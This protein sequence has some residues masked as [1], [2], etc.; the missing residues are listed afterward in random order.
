MAAVVARLRS[1]QFGRSAD[2]W[3]IDTASDKDATILQESRCVILSGRSQCAEQIHLASGGI[4]DFNRIKCPL[5]ASIDRVTG[6]SPTNDKDLPGERTP[7]RVEQNGDVTLAGLQ[8]ARCLREAPRC[9]LIKIRCIHD[10]K[11]PVIKTVPS[12]AMS[13]RVRFGQCALGWLTSNCRSRI[14]G[15]GGR[16]TRIH[17]VSIAAGRASFHQ[18]LAIAEDRGLMP[19]PLHIQR[20]GTG[21]QTCDRVIKLSRPQRFRSFSAA[22]H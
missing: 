17:Q 12:G 16:C 8:D 15:F 13:R 18:H 7:S 21:E 1:D 5:Q 14:V 4:V 2:S 3:T 11:P 19:F 9:W 20:T 6:R 22:R 10:R